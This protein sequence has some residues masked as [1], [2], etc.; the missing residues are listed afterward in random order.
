MTDHRALARLI[1]VAKGEEA[2]LL[3]LNARVINVFTSE[4]EKG[5]VAI[6]EGRVAGVGDYHRGKEVIDLQGRYLSPGFINGHVHIESSLVSITSYAQAVVPHGTSAVVSDLHE[7][8]NVCG[9]KGIRSILY[10]ASS[11]PLR[12]YIM[13]PSCVPST[14]RETSGA[15]ISLDDIRLALKWKGVRGLGEVMSV[16][17]VLSGDEKT[18]LKISSCQEMIV[19]GHAPRLSGKKLNAYI[20]AGISSD[21][22]SVTLEEAQEKLGKGMWIMMRE[23]SAAQ[24]LSSLL[25]LVRDDNYHRFFLVTDD[26]SPSDLMKG[27]MDHVVRK[28][29]ERGLNP[30][31]A[32]QLST[33]N[34]ASYFGLRTSGAIAPGYRADLVAFFDLAHIK[35]DM[36]FF[37]GRL[38]AKDGRPLFSP[39]LPGYQELQSTLNIKPFTLDDL[40]MPE[41]GKYL[42]IIKVFPREILTQKCYG[43]LK[44]SQGCIIPD[45]ERDIL[46]AVVVERHKG[47]GNIGKGMVKGFGLAKGAMASSFSHDAHNVVAV[48]TN[49]H[50]IYKAILEIEKNQGGLALCS[51]GRI[52]SFLP[53]PLAGLLSDQK[54]EEVAKCMSHLEETA[55][56]LG[57]RL[58]SPFATLSFLTLPVIPEVRLTDR[59]IV[60]VD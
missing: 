5:N 25:P 28:A 40:K 45:V 39:L 47:T 55:H 26:V 34:P 44:V 20:S 33:I 15:K 42:P 49:D 24:N 13:L 10:E 17:Q 36:V 59:G 60:E 23:G 22:E 14:D 37:E 58:P 7:I 21:H 32:I 57:C 53:L 29:V 52:L 31:R 43:E 41:E 8:A 1:K 18:L 19:D 56:D 38:T 2:D 4:V 46:K 51:D 35:P 12:L 54:V 27:E 48:G 11:L 9:M 30:L 16:P 50:D 3:L 6:S